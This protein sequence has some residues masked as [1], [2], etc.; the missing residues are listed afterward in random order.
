VNEKKGIFY[1][2]GCQK[3]GDAISFLQEVLSLSFVDAVKTLA[4][5]VGLALPPEFKHGGGSSGQATAAREGAL[6]I[7]FKLNRFVAHFYHEYLL[8]PNGEAARE[9]LSARGVT[10]DSIR[11]WYLGYAPNAWGE[12][13]D[14][15]AARKAPLEKAEEL[16]LVRKKETR[17]SSGRQHYDIFRDRI[18]F[19]VT[20]LRGRVVAFGG[21]ALG[22][23]DGPKY[24]NSPETPIFKKGNHLYGLFHAQ[25]DVRADD[26]AILVEGYMD[27]IALHQHGIGCAVA[28]LG[29]ALSNRQIQVLK[30][31][32]QNIYVL[33]DGDSAGQEAAKKAMELFLAEDLV[34]KGVTIPGEEDPDEY[35]KLHGAEGLKSL[36]A[37]APYLLD[38]RILEIVS[39]A[40]VHVE[41]KARAATQI[42]PWLSKIS[43]EAARA[44]RIEQV[45]GMLGIS[46]ASLTDQVQRLRL[47][48]AGG[49]SSVRTAPNFRGP[50]RQTGTF[51]KRTSKNT[52]AK[53]DALDRRVL[54]LL[55]NSQELVE[56]IDNFEGFLDGLQSEEVRRVVA[57]ILN[58]S[59]IEPTQ[60][61]ELTETPE[62]KNAITRSFVETVEKTDEILQEFRHLVAKLIRRGLERRKDTLRAIILK[63]DGS[64]SSI[65]FQKHMAEYNELIRYLDE[66]KVH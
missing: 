57:Y 43:S 34:V 26:M 32:T 11:K 63:A 29:T 56:N 54:E 27:C 42:V 65:E 44:F 66:T 36:L 19:P 39:A 33:F 8:G 52:N 55:I 25:K 23:S 49:Q 61:L 10:T 17:D 18:I 45:A 64:G 50:V 22:D 35:L 37:S 15:L 14:F 58:H 21:R 38:A 24:L 60:L 5:K 51:S 7:Y 41:G 1:C 59:Q 47:G 62:L 28:T 13:V 53:I 16:G 9:Y 40:G 12:L 48:P 4:A 30:R 2:F 20:D 6:E 46:S 31:L 3:G